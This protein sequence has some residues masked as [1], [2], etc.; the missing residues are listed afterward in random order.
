MF[1]TLLT[2][3]VR[4]LPD[5]D[6]VPYVLVRDIEHTSGRWRGYLVLMYVYSKQPIF[7][8]TQEWFR[9]FFFSRLEYF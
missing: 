4:P 6:V 9:E 2:S 8:P 7:G 1:F 3:G 5:P